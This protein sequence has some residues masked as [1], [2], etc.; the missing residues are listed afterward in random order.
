MPLPFEPTDDDQEQAREAEY[1]LDQLHAFF[2]TPEL[3]AAREL[4]ME[5]LREIQGDG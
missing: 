1:G 3:E 2:D 5:R 4:V